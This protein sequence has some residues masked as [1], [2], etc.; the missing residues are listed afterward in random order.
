MPGNRP[1]LRDTAGVQNAYAAP[2]NVVPI[3]RATTSFRDGPE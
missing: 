3:S 2:L 1:D